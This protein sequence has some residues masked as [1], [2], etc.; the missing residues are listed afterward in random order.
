MKRPKDQTSFAA[1]SRAKTFQTQGSEPELTAN[2]LGSGVN[3]RES[4]AYYDPRSCSWKTSQLLLI[5]G[6]TA[7]SVT[8]PRSGHKVS[9]TGMVLNPRFVEALMGLPDGWTAS[10]A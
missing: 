8:W 10:D 5:E 7:C 9:A 6:L 1:G 2:A 3:L 4:F